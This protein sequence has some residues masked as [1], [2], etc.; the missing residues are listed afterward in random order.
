[1]RFFKEKG[2]FV[3]FIIE[4]VIGKCYLFYVNFFNRILKF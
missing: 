1:M 3:K 2:Y 4:K